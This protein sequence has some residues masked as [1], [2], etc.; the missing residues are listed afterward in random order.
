MGEDQCHLSLN[1]WLYSLAWAS[2]KKTKQTKKHRLGGLI[3]SHLFLTVLVAG[4]S[5]IK[6]PANLVPAAG[7]PFSL[8]T[9]AFLSC[10]HL[11]K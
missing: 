2:I 4:K 8:L 10:P 5:K 11:E 6:V 7:S 1:G 9:A 3:N